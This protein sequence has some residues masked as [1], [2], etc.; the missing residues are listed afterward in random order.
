M[1]SLQ[2]GNGSETNIMINAKPAGGVN[3]SKLIQ[4]IWN[5][6]TARDSKHAAGSV[7]NIA[8]DATGMQTG[9]A[10]KDAEYGI[11]GVLSTAKTVFEAGSQT[12]VSPS[13]RR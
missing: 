3:R 6:N 12:N 5:Y 8:I 11:L 2:T 1:G 7:V 10:N 13:L 9:T 4:G